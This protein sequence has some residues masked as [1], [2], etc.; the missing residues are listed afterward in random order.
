MAQDTEDHRAVT[1]MKKVILLRV[2]EVR[3]KAAEAG[4][5]GQS[6]SLS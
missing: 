6:G 1:E 5:G 4:R 3:A 2:Q